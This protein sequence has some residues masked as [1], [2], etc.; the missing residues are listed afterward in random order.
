[1]SK[2][3]PNIIIRSPIIK[4]EDIT[5][6]TLNKLSA[7]SLPLWCKHNNVKVDHKDLDFTRHRYLLPM[8]ACL[9]PELCIIK[10]SQ[11]GISI[12]MLLKLLWF[13]EQN[14]GTK[15][16][17][18]LP[19]E[20]IALTMSQ[21]RLE[22]M[23]ESCPSVYNIYDKNSKMSLKRFGKSSLYIFSLG[24]VSSKDSVP[25]DFL[26]FDEVRLSNTKDLDQTLNRISH[27]EYK[28]TL[29]GSTCGA[30][31]QTIHARFLGG[32]QHTHHVRCGCLS[33]YCDLAAQFPECIVDDKTR[34]RVYL[35]CT[36]CK[37][38]IKDCQ[39]GRY[40]PLNEGADYTS[41]S[42][43]QL[44]SKFITPKEILRAWETTSDKGEVM[45]SKIGRPYTDEDNR[46]ITLEQVK[47]CINPDLPWYIHDTRPNKPRTAMGIDV[48]KGYIVCSIID[49]HPNGNKKRVRHVEVVDRS[50]S[51]YF[52]EDG[53]QQSPYIRAGELM[54]EFNVGMCVMDHMPNPDE[55]IT[56]AQKFPGR[57]FIA[58]YQDNQKDIVI[59]GDRNRT[60]EGVKKAGPR[61]KFKYH[62]MINRFMAIDA[63]LGEFKMGN[64]EIPDPDKLILSCR[65][66]KTGYVRPEAVCWRFMN[67]LTYAIRQ[68]NITNEDTR[69]GKWVWSY[70]GSQD[71]HALHSISYAN[72]GLEI[73]RKQVIYDFI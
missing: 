13:L 38:E 30:A 65:D 50:N 57:V 53:K 9:D 1:M 33:G 55:A 29:F 40:I 62:V 61:F 31:N 72:L 66:E 45:R 26:V 3:D 25:L 46:G 19:N 47:A 14:Q 60:K 6:E 15:A 69:E 68:L 56:F 71:P 49:I 35:R 7:T 39:N 59:W 41:F 70:S 16:G 51:K 48:G 27:S 36:K 44:A 12:L 43:S 4:P 67:H 54:N 18:Y 11:V 52:S 20:S 23:I 10:A 58:W 17:L 28:W 64:Y 8:Y 5:L 21:D 73:L 2:I 24:G 42:V 34:G 37:Y 63:C 22:P 32:T